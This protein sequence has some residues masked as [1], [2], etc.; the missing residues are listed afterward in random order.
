MP[1]I[2][3]FTEEERWLKVGTKLK[4]SIYWLNQHFIQEDGG[5]FK[6]TLLWE[7]FCNASSKARLHNKADALRDTHVTINVG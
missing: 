6:V 7:P 4:P 2:S 3:Y 1:F 5:T